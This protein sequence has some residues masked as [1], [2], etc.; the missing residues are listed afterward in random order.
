MTTGRPWT[1]PESQRAIRMRLR[2]QMTFAEIGDALGRTE[3][4]VRDH[5]RKALPR[6]RHLPPTPQPTRMS[7]PLRA[8]IAAAKAEA[9]TTPPYKGGW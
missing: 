4:A 5:L 2:Q 3:I 7:N 8:E 9:P 6:V 1:A